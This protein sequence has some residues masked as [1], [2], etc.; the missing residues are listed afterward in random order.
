MSDPNE[1][2][3]AVRQ[4]LGDALG[5][6]YPAA[7]RV[8]AS[9]NIAEHL[10]DGP[11]TA[12]DLAELT[13]M[14]ADH[15]HRVLRFLAGRGVFRE[16]EDGKFHQTTAASLLRAGSPVSLRNLVLLFTG[17]MY[18]LPAGRLSDTVSQGS[19]VFDKLFGA[20]I[21]DHLPTDKAAQELFADAMADLS[22]LEHGG[23]A[24]SYEFPESSTV[25]DIAGG[26]G[27]MLHAILTRNP[28][29]HGVLVD[30]PEILA[31]HR[32]QDPTVADRFTTAEGDFFTS[33][34]TGGDVYLLKRII[35]DKSDEEAV[36]ILRTV[37]AAMSDTA[38]LLVIDIVVPPGGLPHPNPMSDLL[39]MTV[40]EGRERTEGE[41]AALLSAADLKLSRVITTPS[42]MCITEAI[43]I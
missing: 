6:L 20:Q 9:A 1:I 31:R 27:G 34:P 38:R 8:A 2:G 22:V 42:A 10:A 15:L 19:T 16:D 36:H 12:A 35:H 26:L 30:R 24:E 3:A 33:V 28:T 4:L 25:I 32:V 7:L 18:W 37:R 11:R 41:I 13:D 5:Y 21:F 43:A 40:F 39:M 23:M 29:V 14:N 17:D